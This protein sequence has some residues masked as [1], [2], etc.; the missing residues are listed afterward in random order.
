MARL[1]AFFIMAALALPAS[2]GEAPA[3]WRWKDDA[4]AVHITGDPAKIP[5]RYRDKASP[6]RV[7]TVTG[8][9]ESAPRPPGAV[10][11][12]RAAVAFDPSG[13]RIGVEAAFDG[14][15]S[16]RAWVD[17]GSGPV[18]ITT[19][20]AT[21]LGYDTGGAAKKRFSYP[22]GSG[23]APVVTLKSVRVGGAEARDIPAV[24]M[25][26]DGRG[27][28][29][30]VIGMSFLSRFS[31]EVDTA[32]GEM[33]FHPLGRDGRAESQPSPTPGPPR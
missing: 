26:F 17:T 33:V 20:L 30:A 13:E 18:I 25:D 16:R 3:A 21:A 4:G 15:I 24:V 11:G 19:K 2:A 12:G 8:A 6:M 29:S 7:H 32:R 5:P 9:E 10:R 31:F 23:S 22:G 27:P 14:G 28:V 1:A